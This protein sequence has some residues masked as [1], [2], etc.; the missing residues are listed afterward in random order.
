MT[1]EELYKKTGGSLQDVLARIPSEKILEKFARKYL[2]DGSFRQ[3]QEAVQ[4]KD[5]ESAF[6]AAYTLKGV[7]QNLGF[8]RLGKTA[9]E[10]TEALRGGKALTDEKLLENVAAA[11]KEL[12]DALNGLD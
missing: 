4:A 7:A 11:Q 12:S 5:W 9:S 1:L 6:R 8:E 10:L 3:L 2:E